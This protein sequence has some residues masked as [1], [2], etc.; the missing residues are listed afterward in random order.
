MS[1]TPLDY[2]RSQCR[3]DGCTR[4]R[5]HPDRAQFCSGLCADLDALLS[6]VERT[7]RESSSN[8]ATVELWTSTVEAVDAI[9][10]VVRL[11]S[12]IW[13]ESQPDKLLSP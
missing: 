5:R 10:Q 11:H 7:C 13:R 12:R 1:A 9:T 2:R 4:K 3:R 6:K 8:P